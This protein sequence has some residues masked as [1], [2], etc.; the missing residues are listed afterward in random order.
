MSV[1]L[2][3]L[4]FIFGLMRWCTTI[5]ALRWLRNHGPLYHETLNS[6]KPADLNG[7]KIREVLDQCGGPN[8][9]PWGILEYRLY[10]RNRAWRFFARRIYRL[11]TLPI[12]AFFTFYWIGFSGGTISS[13]AWSIV[14]VV[15]QVCIILSAIE[16]IYSYIAIGG[17]RR[18]YHVGIRLNDADQPDIKTNVYELEVLVPL[19]ISAVV[20]NLLAVVVA[21]I[22]WSSFISSQIPLDPKQPAALLVQCLYF[23]FTTMTTVGFGDIIP[24]G[25][26]GQI[27][28][29]LIQIQSLVLIIG[30]FTTMISFGF[31]LNTIRERG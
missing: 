11:P 21:Q 4:F 3:C 12:L 1:I 14:A 31:R 26:W 25:L 16:G 29:I 7:A 27:I 15:Y 8:V 5:G 6:I 22:A 2:A 17:Y 23:V 18:Y 19:A 30:L 13:V 9:W 10:R 28:T 20:I 24:K